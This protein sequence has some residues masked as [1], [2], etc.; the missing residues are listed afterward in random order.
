[1]TYLNEVVKTNQPTFEDYFKEY[2]HQNQQTIT[3]LE[4]ICLTNK[5]D[6]TDLYNFSKKLEESI[7]NLPETLKLNIGRSTNKQIEEFEIRSTEAL[8]QIVA[9]CRAISESMNLVGESHQKL[10]DLVG[11]IAT[12]QATLSQYLSVSEKRLAV[13][14]KGIMA[15]LES[16]SHKLEP[17]NEP[18]KK[19]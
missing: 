13:I 5:Q 11:A 15:L 17:A 3:T 8:R 12:N 2:I 7:I 6:F 18:A 1:M 9:T 4:T 14:E 19:K 10:Y 16:S